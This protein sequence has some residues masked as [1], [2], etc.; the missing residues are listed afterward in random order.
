MRSA[1][2]SFNACA[3]RRRSFPPPTSSE[4][5]GAPPCR[6][7]AAFYRPQ[8]TLSTSHST[9]T[10]RC[11]RGDTV[12][13]CSPRRGALS[14]TRIVRWRALPERF[15]PWNSV[16]K[17]FDRLSKA[18]VFEA[19]FD[20]LASMSSSAHLIQMFDSTI[21]RAHVSAAGAKGG[22]KARRSDARAAASPRKSTRNRTRSGDICCLLAAFSLLRPDG[23]A[24]PPTRG[25][26]TFCSTSAPTFSRAAVICDKAYASKANRE[27]ARAAIA[28]VIPHKA[29]ERECVC[30]PAFFAKTLYKARS[31]IEQGI[32]RLKRFKRVALRCEKTARNFR[33]IVSFAAGL[34]LIKF[35][36]TALTTVPCLV[37]TRVPLT[38]ATRSPEPTGAKSSRGAGA[39]LMTDRYPRDVQIVLVP[40]P[41]A[42]CPEPHRQ[43]KPGK[44]P[45]RRREAWR[46]ATRPPSKAAASVSLLRRIVENEAAAR[47]VMRPQSP[48]SPR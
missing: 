23:A 9:S 4:G 39:R 12:R 37:A 40:V 17:R 31:R 32:G 21:V 22:K 41:V 27:A 46:P 15:G 30:K 13:Q 35:V 24:R 42:G 28:P 20:A 8:G 44:Y 33:S 1:T 26:S 38:L 7:Q 48:S 18:G 36:H 16:W 45:L 2:T 47:S 10:R 11:P 6:R 19:F 5:R 29:N 34:C 3:S 43:V 14:T 25:I